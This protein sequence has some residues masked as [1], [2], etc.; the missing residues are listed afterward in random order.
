MKKLFVF[1]VALVATINSIIVAV[2]HSG[3]DGATK[4]AQ[5]VTAFEKLIPAL[6]ALVPGIPGFVISILTSAP[7]ISILID[8]GVW[9]MNRSTDLTAEVLQDLNLTVNPTPTG[10][11]EV[12]QGP[13]MPPIFND[14][15]SNSTDATPTPCTPVTSPA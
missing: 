2:E 9:A 15:I 8:T 6:G 12:L 10:S 5:V 7:V 1:I 11:P 3:T 13:V 14:S 4:K